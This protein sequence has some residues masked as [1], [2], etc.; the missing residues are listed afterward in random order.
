MNYY[1][2]SWKELFEDKFKDIGD[3]WE[4][5]ESST[6]TEEQLNRSFDSG[7]GIEE[8]D[9]FTVWTKNYVYF[10][11]CYDGSE[12]IGCVARNPDNKPTTHQGGG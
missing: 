10:P 9:P 7:Y 6:L 11:V 5:V 12:W 3:S 4:N 1:N 2:T 8:G